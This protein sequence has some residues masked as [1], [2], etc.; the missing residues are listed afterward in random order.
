LAALCRDRPA[1]VR[2]PL[3]AGLAELEPWLAQWHPAAAP[4]VTALIDAE[5]AGLGAD[6]AALY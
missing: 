4:Q 2:L 5:L 1:A 3:L 6:R